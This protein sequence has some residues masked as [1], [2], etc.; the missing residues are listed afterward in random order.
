MLFDA[1]LYLM[2]IKVWITEFRNQKC[3]VKIYTA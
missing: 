1:E 2:N 3:N